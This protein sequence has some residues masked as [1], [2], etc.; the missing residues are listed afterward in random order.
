MNRLLSAKLLFLLLML[1]LPLSPGR[2]YAHAALVEASPLPGGQQEA[3]PNQ[4]RLLFNE[5]LEKQLME[6]TVRDSK[7][8]SI[9]NQAPDMSQ[10]QKELR[11]ALPSLPNGYY[12][13][14]YRVLSADG[15]PVDGS[16]VF[17]VGPVSGDI[18][19]EGE[20]AS[21]GHEHGQ[22]EG[23]VMFV[24]GIAAYIGL[25]GVT[26]W[27]LWCCFG[28][29]LQPG[30]GAIHSPS[31]I[32][33]FSRTWGFRLLLLQLAAQAACLGYT[34]WKLLP[35]GASWKEL[36]HVLTGT[37]VGLSMSIGLILACLGFGILFRWKSLDLLWVAAALLTKCFNGHA[38]AT[39]APYVSLPLDL[40]H[41]LAAAVWAGGLLYILVHR[42]PYPE[43][44][45]R[46][47]PVFSRAALVSFVLLALTGLALTLLLQPDYT[48]L[49]KTSWGR[50]LL[51]KTALVLAAAATAGMIRRRM[52]A[53][54]DP[55]WLL[56]VDFSTMV[57]IVV[58]VGIFTQ[59]SPHPENKP[60]SLAE[61]KANLQLTAGITPN[62]PGVNRV[63]V[64]VEMPA[65]AGAPK[66]V[67][68]YLKS[69]GGER[70][71]P[72]EVPLQ[73]AKEPEEGSASGTILYSYEDTG[74][75]LPF[76]G[77]WELEVRI[78]S[79]ADD[80]TVFRREFELYE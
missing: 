55:G 27:I 45:R 46:F 25:I 22:A 79:A 16:Y 4:I 66:R 10:D 35:A 15:H 73:Q 23:S 52:R 57:L 21:S 78:M 42:G 20:A 80:E 38:S 30:Q 48:L 64:Q 8:T 29:R 24:L 43:Q 11:L 5:R 32:Q 17:T 77:K 51:A 9:T 12:T 67:Q 6:L 41:L 60:L 7:G 14:S 62:T 59:L 36:V 28:P 72:I 74:P 19:P 39:E 75:Y 69:I 61:R 26:G 71:P 54:R 56:R 13:V 37:T 50:L 76:A 49:L 2:I 53:S 70:I 63:Q 58:I 65:Q 31:G 1:L 33:R 3:S 40:I 47:L 18:P 44:V 34:L 68:A